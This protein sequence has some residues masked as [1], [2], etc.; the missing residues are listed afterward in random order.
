MKKL[1]SSPYTR[2]TSDIHLPQV[3][4]TSSSHGNTSVTSSNTSRPHPIFQRVSLI[5]DQQEHAYK[6]MKRLY[7]TIKEQEKRSFKI[8]DSPYQVKE[9]NIH[10]QLFISELGRVVG[11]FWSSFLLKFISRTYKPTDKGNN[12][13]GQ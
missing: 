7:R 10:Y 4:R 8:P 5:Y 3:Q 1:R 11:R 2:F 9:Y 6:M 13:K 12:E